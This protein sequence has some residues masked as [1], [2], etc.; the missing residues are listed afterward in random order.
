MMLKLFATDKFHMII[1][2]ATLSG[3][4]ITMLC[5]TEICTGKVTLLRGCSE[6]KYFPP[7]GYMTYIIHTSL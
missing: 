3:K 1:V 2:Q 6:Q 7:L 4:I 5:R